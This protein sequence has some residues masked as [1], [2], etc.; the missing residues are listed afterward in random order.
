[1]P[2]SCSNHREL[3]DQEF[4]AALSNVPR[5]LVDKTGQPARTSLGSV[6]REVEI[7]RKNPKEMLE[8]KSTLM[9][10]TSGLTCRPDGAEERTSELGDT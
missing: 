3:S 2:T 4:K 10:L 1:M 8:I 6:S 9:P 7:P 5:A